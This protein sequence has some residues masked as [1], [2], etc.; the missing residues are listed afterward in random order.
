[1]SAPK[2]FVTLSDTRREAR[3]R[4]IESRQRLYAAV[5]AYCLHY[6]SMRFGQAVFHVLGTQ[7]VY[8]IEN[9][10]LTARLRMMLP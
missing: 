4:G 3:D 5:E 9:D 6:P 1:M 7:D 2:Q 8:Y 10:E